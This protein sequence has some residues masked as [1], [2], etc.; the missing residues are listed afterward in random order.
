GQ[1][2]RCARQTKRW[3]WAPHQVHSPKLL[4]N[5]VQRKARKRAW[6]RCGAY[7]VR[8]PCEEADVDLQP[9]GR[10]LGQGQRQVRARVFD[11]LRLDPRDLALLE[12]SSQLPVNGS[13]AF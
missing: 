12:R 5:S 11:W 10:P 3:E 4:P 8:S 7:Q 13:H 2:R 1:S 9:I 6:V